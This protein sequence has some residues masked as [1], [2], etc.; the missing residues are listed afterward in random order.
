MWFAV[1]TGRLWHL[2]TG[3]RPP[4]TPLGLRSWPET[5]PRPTPQEGPG[6][7]GILSG[8]WPWF[9][10]LQL[11]RL[12]QQPWGSGTWCRCPGLA[13]C[14]GCRCE[15]WG[16]PPPWWARVRAT[17]AFAQGKRAAWIDCDFELWFQVG[18][19]LFLFFL[20]QTGYF[21]SFCFYFE[22]GISRG[23]CP[24]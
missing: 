3:E 10:V 7:P 4:A 1:C 9:A 6:V 14:P 22:N 15:R 17:D 12:G 11:S 24:P 18:C 21:L 16:G 5:L 19:F 8:S 20:T 23:R 2:M 13:G